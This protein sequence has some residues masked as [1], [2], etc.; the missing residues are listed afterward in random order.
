MLSWE[1]SLT[2]GQRDEEKVPP[3][4]SLGVRG[5]GISMNHL[6]ILAVPVLML[7]DYLLTILGAKASLGVY[8]QHFIS[9]HY[10][11]NPLWQK[12]VQQLKWFSPLHFI[13]ACA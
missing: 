4:R 12:C 6:I 9:P 3:Q 8:R 1:S 10:E 2:L 11:I 5:R 7:S 13:L